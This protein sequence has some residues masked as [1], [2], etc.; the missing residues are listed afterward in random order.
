MMKR[1]S[2]HPEGF[3]THKVAMTLDNPTCNLYLSMQHRLSHVCTLTCTLYGRHYIEA[4]LWS[5]SVESTVCVY[6]FEYAAFLLYLGNFQDK[7]LTPHP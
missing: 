7:D 5:F 3:V 4:M 1:F 6:Y 2:S